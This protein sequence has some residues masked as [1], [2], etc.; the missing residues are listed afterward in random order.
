MRV[1]LDS[2]RIIRISNDHGEEVGEAPHKPFDLG[3]LRYSVAQKKLLDLIDYSNFYVEN[4]N[5]VLIL[6]VEKLKKNWQAV[7][8]AYKDRKRLINIGNKIQLKT[9][10]MINAEKAKELKYRTS[11]QA[12]RLTGKTELEELRDEI[13][14]LKVEK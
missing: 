9:N 13:E 7:K 10:T 3:R 11:V 5:G 6:H 1:I 8:M 12:R 14:K 4:N 2:D